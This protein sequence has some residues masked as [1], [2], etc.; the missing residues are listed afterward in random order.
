MLAR[1]VSDEASRCVLTWP[2]LCAHMLGISSSSYVDTSSVRLRP[3]LT[4]IISVKALPP[5]R[6][7]LRAEASTYDFSGD[8]IQSVVPR[9]SAATMFLGF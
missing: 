9:E 1:L 6:I 3:Y 8:K 4:L 2:S 7:T 5:N